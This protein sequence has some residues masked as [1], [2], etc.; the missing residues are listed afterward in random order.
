M[1]MASDTDGTHQASLL[2]ADR[3]FQR[4]AG[5]GSQVKLME[6]ADGM[7][8]QEVYAVRVQPL[9]RA[10]DLAHADSCSLRLVLFANSG[11][12]RARLPIPDGGQQ[13]SGRSLGSPRTSRDPVRDHIRGSQACGQASREPD[14][15]RGTG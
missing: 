11:G 10:V 2:R 15:R 12:L 13:G 6:V 8:L 7:Q 5:P 9:Q 1:A 14:T 3:R 4:A